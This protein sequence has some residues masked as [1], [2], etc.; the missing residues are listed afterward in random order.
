[1]AILTTPSWGHSFLT[2]QL[3]IYFLNRENIG[4][5][6]PRI[7]EKRQRNYIRRSDHFFI[8]YIL[9]VDL[10]SPLL[11]RVEEWNLLLPIN[12]LRRWRTRLLFSFVSLGHSTIGVQT[13]FT[14]HM[15][16]WL[17]NDQGISDKYICNFKH[18]A[19]CFSY[20]RV[21]SGDLA[22][23]S[24]NYLKPFSCCF[25]FNITQSTLCQ[26]YFSIDFKHK[27]LSGEI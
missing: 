23:V 14:K 2:P 19:N 8:L 16:K 9:W 11:Y 22:L 6:A 27:I 20:M 7:L 10:K 4:E 12:F 3:L 17:G 18:P 1:M 24:A 26:G 15:N 13:I 5:A 21:I 25:G